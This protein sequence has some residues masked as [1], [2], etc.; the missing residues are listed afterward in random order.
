MLDDD[1]PIDPLTRAYGTSP[2]DMDVVI[3]SLEFGKLLIGELWSVVG[4]REFEGR[5]TVG[6]LVR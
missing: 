2:S 6:E 1:S 5:Q 3:I 4:R